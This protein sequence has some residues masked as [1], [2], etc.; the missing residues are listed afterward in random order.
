[1]KSMQEQLLRE[2]K[3]YT[4]GSEPSALAMLQAPRID[5]WEPEVRRRGKEFV[6]VIRGEVTKHPDIEDG[7]PIQ[8]SV[9]IWF[10][11]KGHFVRTLNRIYALGKPGTTGGV[12]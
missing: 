10:D 6:L 8:T 5:Y 11:R 2:I 9:V 4:R 12:R 3:S 7:D 1:M